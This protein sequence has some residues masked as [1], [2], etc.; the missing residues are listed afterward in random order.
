MQV[1]RRCEKT[2]AARFSSTS[3]CFTIS[4]CQP[5]AD[6]PTPPELQSD[7]NEVPQA[8]IV[9][10]SGVNP[11]TCPSI[12]MAELWL[13]GKLIFS[14]S[15]ESPTTPGKL[16]EDS[17]L[18]AT[19]GTDYNRIFLYHTNGNSSDHMK[20]TV[21]IKNLGCSSATL[22]VERKGR[23]G[24]T[25]HYA[26]GGKVAFFRWLNSESDEEVEIAPGETVSLDTA[27][28]TTLAR[29]TYLMHGIWD[30]SF[31]QP[32]QVTI[33]ALNPDDDPLSVCPGLEVL[34]R[35]THTRGT[36][37]NADKTYAAVADTIIDTSG[38][39]QQFPIAQQSTGDTY[40][41]GTD[42]TDGAEVTNVG[43]YGILYHIYLDTVSGDGRN[44]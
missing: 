8:A 26:Y 25:T 44:L 43:N 28:D 13:G 19:S 10:L 11:L 34:P 39:I 18:E 41:L 1:R 27:L 35:D 40:A 12:E 31:T 16:Y 5:G 4:C 3:C 7:L 36:F 23:A 9:S 15:P 42:A 6:G 33:C 21:L 14:N 30:Y 2:V 32:H 22:R 37:P 29:E 17:A 20:F 24:P 38:D